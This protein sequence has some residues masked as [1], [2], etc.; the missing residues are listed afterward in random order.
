[1]KVTLPYNPCIIIPCYEKHATILENTIKQYLYLNLPILII[2]DGSSFEFAKMIESVATKYTC[3]LIRN[4]KNGGKGCAIKHGLKVAHQRKFSHA[5]QI[6]SDGQHSP[7]QIEVL[8][9]ESQKHPTS[10]ISGSPI[11]DESISKARYYGRYLT[12]FWVWIHTLSFKIKDS[13]CGYRVYPLSK[14]I[15]V[16]TKYQVGNKMDFDIEIMVLL[17]WENTKI[18]F[19]EVPVSYPKENVSY[20]NSLDDNILISKMHTKLFFKMLFKSPK[21]I[22]N[23]FSTNENLPWYKNDEKGSYF[24]M[25]LTL[26]LFKLSGPRPVKFIG[27]FIS[28]YYSITSKETSLRS[29]HFKQ[30]YKD[31]CV[32]QNIDY[33]NFTTYDHINSFTEMVIDK[34]SVWSKI[35][36]RKNINATDLIEYHKILNQEK[37]AFFISSHFGNLEII[38]SIG[39]TTKKF[40]INTL[41]YTDNSQKILSLINKISADSMVGII[42]INEISPSLAINLKDKIENQELIFCMGDRITINSN[43]SLPVKML[44]KEVRLPYGPFLIAHLLNAP[45]YSIHCYKDKNEYRIALK[46]INIDK[47]LD[48]NINI[49]KI[50]QSYASEVEDLIIKK[51]TQW[52]NFNNFWN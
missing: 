16:L 51:P 9:K 4:E 48:K 33:H 17:F 42:N 10:L 41:M 28:R 39:Q 27:K 43:K 11:Y 13:M 25:L 12:H 31:Y 1:M 2:D 24:L 30:I 19:I 22:A 6:D 29:E 8:I 23:K 32:N 38:R 40:K 18:H 15:D 49:G 21:I 47:T 3:H 46:E 20:F 52:F 5:I 35:I 37:G 36:Q 7:S 50:A 26:N 34:L 44:D 14:T 45:T